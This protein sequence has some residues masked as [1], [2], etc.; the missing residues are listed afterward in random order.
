MKFFL[1]LFIY[2]Y[3]IK[4]V[5]L[6]YNFH[7]N[8]LSFLFISPVFF[9]LLRFGI[10]WIVKDI[11]VLWFRFLLI[12]LY[13]SLFILYVFH[14]QF[15]FLNLLFYNR[16]CRITTLDTSFV[17]VWFKVFTFWSLR[18]IFFR[19]HIFLFWSWFSI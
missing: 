6:I 11:S 7:F 2:V 14:V 13:F 18:I 17:L 3:K 8:F 1:I 12:F 15:I 19:F 16:L 10:R 9:R 4:L 5:S